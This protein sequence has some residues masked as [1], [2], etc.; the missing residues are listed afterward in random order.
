MAINLPR[1]RLAG[2][3]PENSNVSWGL[4]ALKVLRLPENSIRGVLPHCWTQLGKLVVLDLT[5]NQLAGRIPT[6]IGDLESLE[7]LRLGDNRFVGDLPFSLRYCVNLRR[8]ETYRNFKL[9]GSVRTLSVCSAL[10]SHTSPRPPP[11]RSSSRSRRSWRCATS[12]SR[13]AASTG[14]S[15]RR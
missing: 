11:P 10:D 5:R 6:S 4:G 13:S 8:L 9:T 1:N 2:S 7:Q 14:R 3:L 15:R 12:V